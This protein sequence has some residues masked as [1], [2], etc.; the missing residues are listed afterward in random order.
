MT[1]HRFNVTDIVTRV[2]KVLVPC[3]Q[4]TYVAVELSGSPGGGLCHW[5]HNSQDHTEDAPNLFHVRSIPPQ[6]LQNTMKRI[7]FQLELVSFPELVQSA[8]VPDPMIPGEG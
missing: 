8:P 7:R 3:I 4:P 5:Q 6:D 2:Q 1:Q